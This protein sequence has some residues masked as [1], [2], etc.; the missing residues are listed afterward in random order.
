MNSKD[1]LVAA[2]DKTLEVPRILDQTFPSARRLQP[3]EQHSPPLAGTVQIGETS[4]QVMISSLALPRTLS[5][6]KSSFVFR[7]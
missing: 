3:K 7:S 4:F 5:L 6:I 1:W 2:P